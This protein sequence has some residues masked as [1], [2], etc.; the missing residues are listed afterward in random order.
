LA[1]YRLE[2]FLKGIFNAGWR[3]GYIYLHGPE[4]TLED[5]REARLRLCA[6]TPVQKVA[7]SALR[8][9]HK[10]VK[11]MVEKLRKRRD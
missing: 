1:S 10:Y 6:N 7:V 5:L 2:W 9:S 8:G 3:L 11:E 4:N